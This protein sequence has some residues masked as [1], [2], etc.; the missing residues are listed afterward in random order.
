MSKLEYKEKSHLALFQK[1][2]ILV[3]FSLVA[4]Q[5]IDTVI[6]NISDF[7]YDPEYFFLNLFLATQSG[8]NFFV[9]LCILFIG[10]QFIFLYYIK[11][12]LKYESS[13]FSIMY[14]I[15]LL[16]HLVMIGILIITVL[17]I[18]IQNQYSFYLSKIAVGIGSTFASIIFVLLSKRL[19]SWYK[20]VN[21][22]LILLFG[23]AFL[24]LGITKIVFELGI[25]ISLYDYDEMITSGTIVEFPDYTR[26]AVLSFF[27]DSY[28]IFAVISFFLLWL[29]TVFLIQ[30]YK[31]AVG[32]NKYRMLTILSLLV[33]V[34]TPIGIY[35][36]ESDIGNVIDPVAFYIFTTFNSTIA[37]ILFFVTFSTLSRSITS[38][39]PLKNYLFITGIGLLLYFI[40]DQ[41]TI[42]QHAYPPYGMISLV[43][44]GYSA[45][46]IFVGILSSA[47]SLSRNIE[48]RKLVHNI[49]KDRFL[50]DISLGQLY[51]ENETHVKKIIDN[52]PK[53]DLATDVVPLETEE[54][55]GMVN[56]VISQLQD[57][58]VE[59][60][61]KKG[62]YVLQLDC[63]R[64]HKY[65][66][67]QVNVSENVSINPIFIEYPKSE[68]I[69]CDRCGSLI[70]LNGSSQLIVSQY[71]SNS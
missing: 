2:G 17:N 54:I 18:I 3:I 5:L 49:L 28:W 38:E 70:G 11:L 41:S 52:I 61:F 46:L 64:C 56:E 59:E 44:L 39:Y 66:R 62:Y 47:I 43:F 37:A 30:N 32:K 67:I 57:I 65:Y 58:R 35:F 51:T 13:L 1:I 34:P 8:V 9:V 48:V 12:Y 68:K 10:I 42:E 29:G 20:K 55:H 45:Y 25:F 15:T 23:F 26:N 27:Q 24:L 71:S 21:N 14:K 69:E 40:S 4:I 7:Q 36:N 22:N 31:E 19:F 33:F 60:D 6:G 16:L 53:S 63:I 50:Y